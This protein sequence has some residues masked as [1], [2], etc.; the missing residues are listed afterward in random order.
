MEVAERRRLFF[1]PRL[2]TADL[3]RL[4][5]GLDFRLR[6]LCLGF[7]LTRRH[8]VPLHPCIATLGLLAATIRVHVTI[9]TRLRSR[10]LVRVERRLFLSGLYFGFARLHTE[11]LELFL[12]GG[13][14]L[15]GELLQLVL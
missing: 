11:V 3:C 13:A 10:Y 4:H 1:H 2:E 7:Q 6:G 8:L 9:V 5:L 14:L 15:L 12:L